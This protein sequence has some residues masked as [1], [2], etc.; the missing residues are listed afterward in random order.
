MLV[1]VGLNWSKL[2]PYNETSLMYQTVEKPGIYRIA[3]LLDGKLRVVYVGKGENVGE[4]LRNH[5]RFFEPNSFLKGMLEEKECYF[6]YCE[7]QDPTDRQ[8]VEYTL[9]QY[10][11]PACNIIEPKGHSIDLNLE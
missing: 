10:Y 2:F 1:R 9:Y 3:A 7:V 4:K 11:R 5:R 6:S 8:N